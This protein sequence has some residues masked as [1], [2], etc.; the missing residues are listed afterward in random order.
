MGK[1]PEGMQIDRK[2]N[3]KGY[4]PDNCRWATRKQQLRNT[5]RNRQL[6]FKGETKCLSAW[7]EDFGF[8]AQLLWSRIVRS[9]WS[10][11]K[12]LGTPVRVVNK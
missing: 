6:T 12:A 3:N 2:D 9:G 11:E 4:S 1:R 8:S 10:V 7:A 5:R